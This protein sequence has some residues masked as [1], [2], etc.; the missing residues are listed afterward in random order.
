MSTRTEMNASTFDERA[1]AGAASPSPD[2]WVEDAESGE[3]R[4][5][6]EIGCEGL[7]QEEAQ[8]RLLQFGPNRLDEPRRNGLL[9]FLVLFWRPGAWLVEAVAV[10]LLASRRIGDFVV[11]LIVLSVGAIV[12]LLLALSALRETERLT[13]RFPGAA[14]VKRSGRWREIDASYLVPG[15][16]VRLERNEAVPA[17]VLLLAGAPIS[18]IDEEGAGHSVPVIRTAGEKAYWGSV[19]RAGEMVARVADTGERTAFGRTAKFVSASDDSRTLQE[20]LATVGNW[21]I[22]LSLAVAALLFLSMLLRNASA[23][24][25]AELALVLIVA[26]IPVTARALF[27]IAAALPRRR[28]RQ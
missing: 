13:K 16:I 17:D 15:D 4:K 9:R 14:K 1:S 3:L 28:T 21:L 26:A 20:G 11:V 22:Y 18:I 12:G 7:S 10:I 5:L 19:V 2:D 6:N 23:R 27:S 8:R 24:T 25:L